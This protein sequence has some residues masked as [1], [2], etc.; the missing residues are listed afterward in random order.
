[1]QLHSEG[2]EREEEARGRGAARPEGRMKEVA[3]ADPAP[4]PGRLPERPT[5]GRPA[6]GAPPPAIPPWASSHW[7]GPGGVGVRLCLT[8][9]PSSSRLRL[10]QL[11]TAAV[12]H[13]WTPPQFN[14]LPSK[15]AGGG[16]KGEA[17]NLGTLERKWSK[18]KEAEPRIN[19]NVCN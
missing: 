4:S 18:E 1:M 14:P 19:R 2:W 9:P 3:Q 15:P 13:A 5:T 7:A 17:E 8:A 16:K 12:V 11:V 10:F 6:L